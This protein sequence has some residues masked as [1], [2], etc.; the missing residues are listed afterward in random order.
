MPKKIVALLN[1]SSRLAQLP[2]EHPALMRFK[3]RRCSSLQQ[4][5]EWIISER[6]IKT[7]TDIHGQTQDEGVGV[8][9]GRCRVFVSQELAANGALSL[10]NLACWLLDKQIY[11]LAEK[12]EQE[13]GF[14]ERMHR[15]RKQKRD[16]N[17]NQ[18]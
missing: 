9:D 12:F 17:H 10:L 5:R 14:S 3:S 4:F 8:R 2:P 11:C 18:H 13:G 15:I 6:K 1:I 16:G 7:P